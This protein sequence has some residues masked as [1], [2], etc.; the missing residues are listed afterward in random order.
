MKTA[1][2]LLA[3]AAFTGLTAPVFCEEPAPFFEISADVPEPVQAVL[4]K[5][6]DMV[7]S[8]Q[9]CKAA[10]RAVKDKAGADAAAD[11]LQHEMRA[12]CSLREDC[13][14]IFAANPDI[15]PPETEEFAGD[16]TLSKLAIQISKAV[17]ALQ[18][19]LY[20]AAEFCAGP[21]DDFYGS[22]Q[23]AEAVQLCGNVLAWGMTVEES[24]ATPAMVE[25]LM[26]YNAICTEAW[27]CIASV[28]DRAGADAAAT[29]LADLRKRSD[30]VTD[31]MKSVLDTLR[32]D[33]LPG[34]MGQ[35]SGFAILNLD[36]KTRFHMQGVQEE[37]SA[38]MEELRG[39]EPP[40]YGSAAFEENAGAFIMMP[41]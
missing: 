23:L 5:C 30:A 6:N 24:A 3:A 36:D 17:E 27:E 31:R 13:L 11:V 26:E 8:L 4:A 7:A 39:M 1:S 29:Q 25:A 19:P 20:E 22:S 38:K 37:A 15:F 12:F 2:L 18:A 28:Q 9:R 32:Q 10:M 21:D 14:Q 41:R 33:R 16:V 34:F 40:F 35:V